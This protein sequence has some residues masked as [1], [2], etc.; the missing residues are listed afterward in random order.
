MAV[1]SRDAYVRIVRQPTGSKDL[2]EDN[3]VI[4]VNRISGCVDEPYSTCIG[5]RGLRNSTVNSSGRQFM[6]MTVPLRMLKLSQYI[7]CGCR[8][9]FASQTDRTH[10]AVRG[11]TRLVGA[12]RG[13]LICV[14]P[15]RSGIRAGGVVKA[16]RTTSMQVV[17]ATVHFASYARKRAGY[18]VQ[19]GCEKQ[20]ILGEPIWGTP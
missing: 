18:S 19:L 15:A 7:L 10:L 8:C 2:L 17:H 14:S 5:P 16:T 11:L 20:L 12:A 6:R 13:L 4:S 3:L 9:H 1:S